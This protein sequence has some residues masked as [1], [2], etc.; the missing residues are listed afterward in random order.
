M[1]SHK[2]GSWDDMGDSMAEMIENAMQDE[3][4]LAYPGQSLPGVLD[5]QVMFVA[6]AK[7]V[8]RYLHRHQRSIGTTKDDGDE[9]AHHL[10]FDLEEKLGP[11]LEPGP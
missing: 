1:A 10:N 6:I 8:L 3:W 11:P 2:A 4:G 9:H 7:G 5:R